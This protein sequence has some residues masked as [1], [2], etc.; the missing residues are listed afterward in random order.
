M[1]R[2]I[3]PLIEYVAESATACLVTM[4]QGNLL[5]ITL[6]HL[7]IASQT[8]VIAAALA[9]IALR[10]ART[11]RRWI[12]SIVLGVATGVVDFYVHP[13][14]FGSVAMEASLTGVGAALLSFLV[15]TTLRYIR[16]KSAA[17]N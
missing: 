9:S 3:T 8:G 10:V 13:G 5:A 6:S 15:G 12:I 4:V 16:R 1:H 11:R 7:L 17:T 2:K 14:M